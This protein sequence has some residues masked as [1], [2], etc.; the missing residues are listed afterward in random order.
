MVPAFVGVNTCSTVYVGCS[1][2]PVLLSFFVPPGCDMEYD[3]VTN[4]LPVM[5]T[6]Q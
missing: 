6:N 3:G 1:C 5:V 4:M 2:M